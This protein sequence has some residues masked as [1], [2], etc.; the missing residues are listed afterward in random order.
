MHHLSAVFLVTKSSDLH[1]EVGAAKRVRLDADG[2]CGTKSVFGELGRS[3]HTY[4]HVCTGDRA[5]A[6]NALG[7]CIIRHRSEGPWRHAR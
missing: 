4:S 6:N 2:F 5:R 1:E 3:L 7:G